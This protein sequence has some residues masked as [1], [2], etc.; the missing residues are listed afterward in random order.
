MA[1]SARPR[2]VRLSLRPDNRCQSTI[3]SKD[4]N[5]PKILRRRSSSASLTCWKD[6]S[7][8][9]PSHHR[10]SG[11]LLRPTWLLLLNLGSMAAPFRG[12]CSLDLLSSYFTGSPSA[13]TLLPSRRASTKRSI[14]ANQRFCL[15]AVIVDPSRPSMKRRARGGWRSRGGQASVVRLRQIGSEFNVQIQ[16]TTVGY[17]YSS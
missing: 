8:H 11:L 7:R 16:V 1:F 5:R 4:A 12:Y 13:S 10:S 9:L 14:A 6:P 2:K 17:Y 3:I 15:I